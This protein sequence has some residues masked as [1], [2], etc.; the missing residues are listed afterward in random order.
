MALVL[1]RS[2]GGAR[3]KASDPLDQPGVLVLDRE[4]SPV[5]RTEAATQ[6]IAALPLS[7]LFA[8]WGMLPAVIYPAATLA[9]AGDVA[10]AHATLPVTTAAGSGSRRH[11]WTATATETSP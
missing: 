7:D 2:V 11:H 8:S 5:S 6:W 4:L 3:R 10:R 9:R 1:R